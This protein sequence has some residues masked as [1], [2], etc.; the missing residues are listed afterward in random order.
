MGQRKLGPHHTHESSRWGSEAP[1]DLCGES[2]FFDPGN[3]VRCTPGL[4]KDRLQ[5]GPMINRNG[6][7]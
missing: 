1:Q 6:K 5:V 3:N 4:G 7:L 2:S